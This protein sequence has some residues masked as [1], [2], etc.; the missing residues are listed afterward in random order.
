MTEYIKE[1]AHINKLTDEQLNEIVLMCL[2]E[3]R[4]RDEKRFLE[5]VDN[6]V[7]AIDILREEFPDAKCIIKCHHCGR[8][9]EIL[10]FKPCRAN[11]S[12][13]QRANHPRQ[14]IDNKSSKK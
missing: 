13:N 11:F 1:V 12:Y 9:T 14:V 4:N 6:V 3:Q 5:L 8:E 7:W 10:S 2:E